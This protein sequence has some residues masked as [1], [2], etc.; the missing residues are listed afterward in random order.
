ML[1][2]FPIPSSRPEWPVFSSEPA[3]ARRVAERA[4]CV[5]RASPG[6]RDHGKQSTFSQP[7]VASSFFLAS[8]AIS[9]LSLKLLSASCYLIAVIRSLFPLVNFH[10]AISPIPFPLPLPQYE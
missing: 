7:A 9:A 5:L 4:F 8:S 6:P 10:Y 3:A 2:S 1:F